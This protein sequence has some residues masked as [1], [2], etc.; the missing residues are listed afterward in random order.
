MRM[1]RKTIVPLLML[2]ASSAMTAQTYKGRVTTAAGQPLANVSVL[3]VNE[4]GNNVKFVRT[5]KDGHFSVDV[6]EGK[7]VS[8]IAFVRLGYARQEMEIG[9]YAKGSKT[10]AMTEQVQQIREVKVTPEKFRVKGDTLIYSVTGYRE[11]QDRTIEDVIARLP[12]VRVST[13]GTITYQGKAINKFYVDG[14]DMLGG[15]YAMVTKN[16]SADKVDSVQVL[17]N[18]QPVNA[19]RG[20]QFSDVAAMN[21]VLK[22]GV[23]LKWT[24]TAELGSGMFLQHPWKWTRKARLVEMFFGNKLQSLSMYK[25]NNVAENVSREVQLMGIDYSD[26]SPLNNID[27][28]G[29]GRDGFNDSHLLATNWYTKI[30]ESSNVRLQLSAL[31]DKSTRHHYS[32]RTY[33][34]IADNATVVEDRTSASYTQ[35]YKGELNYSY[36]GSKYYINDNLAGSMSF[37][38]SCASTMLNGR[39]T[40]EWVR[41][42]KRSITNALD[43]SM[44]PFSRNYNHFSSKLSYNYLPGRLLLYNGTME[45]VNLKTLKWE[46]EHN[47]NHRFTSWLSLDLYSSY[48]MERKREHVAYNDTLSNVSYHKDEISVSPN[49]TF[50][51]NKTY[52]TVR[53]SLRWLSRILGDDADRRWIYEPGI[54]GKWQMSSCWQA[55]GSYS[56]SFSPSGFETVNPLRVYTSYNYASSGTGQHDHST[57]DNASIDVH[58]LNPSYGWDA[59]LRYNYQ[60]NHYKHLYESQLHDGVYIRE[61]VSE[62]NRSSNQNVGGSLGRSFRPMRTHVMV[63]ADYGWSGCDILYD[64]EKMESRMRSLSLYLKWRMRPFRIFS[65]EESSSFHY[66]HQLSKVRSSSTRSF[67]HTMNLYLQPG[68]W[69]LKVSGECRHSPDRSEKFTFF[70]DATLSYK[71]QKYELSFTCKNLVGTDRREY[72]SISTTGSSYSMTELRPREV[73]ASIIFNI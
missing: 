52:L 45:E 25:H 38:H 7:T 55:R 4:K 61:S 49:L 11:K 40:G 12:G 33:L 34:D 22:E 62:D 16:L 3:L 13:D 35:Q 36:N 21:L 24:G 53:N 30:G 8:R 72:R 9:R 2:L 57:G 51:G 23:K 63:R 47:F 41:P 26:I 32:E 67:S 27:G 42:H 14:K 48:R 69:Q 65:V 10:V 44:S 66:Y 28:I 6:P 46:T 29:E 68:S 18:H 70:S 54:D 5:D 1:K 17:Q 43:I 31:F 50:G 73:M 64:K 19:L 15:S 20:K 59:N 39:E 37:D 56:H 71:T 58:Y 60:T